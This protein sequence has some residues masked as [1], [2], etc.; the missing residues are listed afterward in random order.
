MND[1][2]SV[3]GLNFVFGSEIDRNAILPVF[4]LL[5]KLTDGVEQFTVRLLRCFGGIQS[6]VN[7]ALDG[8][9]FAE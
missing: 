1:E 9:E 4:Q 8:S 3:G 6:L 7:T 5:I 2:G